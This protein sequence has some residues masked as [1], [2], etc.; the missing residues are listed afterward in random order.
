MKDRVFAYIKY[1]VFLVAVLFLYLFNNH[2]VSLM[3]L[4]GTLIFPVVDVVLHRMLGRRIEVTARFD[5]TLCNR[6]RTVH[7]ILSVK[8]K[9]WYPQIRVVVRFKIADNFSTNDYLHEYTL[10]VGSYKK[11]EYKVP[12]HFAYC[13]IFRAEVCSATTWDMLHFSKMD[14]QVATCSEIVVMPSK[15]DLNSAMKELQGSSDEEDLVE[16]PQKGNDPSEIFEL[17][18][19]QQGDRLNTIHWKVSAKESELIVKEFGDVTG[20]LFRIYLDLSYKDTRQKDAYFDLLYSVCNEL[21]QKRIFFSVHWM[22]KKNQNMQKQRIYT[23][24]DVLGAV[25]SLF[26]IE[27]RIESFAASLFEN[28][29][30]QVLLLT[31]QSYKRD[32]R[33]RL[34]AS[35]NNL[36]RLYEYTNR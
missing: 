24:D 7:L 10:M 23:S 11:E 9:S 12:M 5:E 33:F 26:Y 2:P 22:S 21:C 32:E 36:A 16:L 19:Y 6:N 34:I 4:Y 8:N 31:T 35:N 20:E 28:E 30:R 13:G 3:L 18:A 27:P 14:L 25:I 17:R 29:N 1:V 15:I